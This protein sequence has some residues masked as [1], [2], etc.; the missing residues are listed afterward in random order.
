MISI[1]PNI[2]PILYYDMLDYYIFIFS[3]MTYMTYIIPKSRYNDTSTCFYISKILRGTH[4]FGQFFADKNVQCPTWSPGP[5]IP[6]IPRRVVSKKVW[7]LSGF[8]VRASLEGLGWGPNP[9]MTSL[10]SWGGTEPIRTQ[11]NMF[12]ENCET[13]FLWK[14]QEMKV[15]FFWGFWSNTTSIW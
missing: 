15:W 3:Y 6:S 1:E 9:A 4:S 2:I 13:K 10:P 5:S 14:Q 8:Q 11:E 12:L 7:H